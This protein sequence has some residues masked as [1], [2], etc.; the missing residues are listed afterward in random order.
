MPFDGKDFQLWKYQMEIIFRAE[1]GMIEVV[2]GIKTRPGTAGDARTAWD[3]LN[4]KAMLLI[5]SGMEYEQLQTVVSC[6]TAP[7]MWT[8]LKAIHE[9]RSAINKMTL[10]QQFYNYRMSETDSIAQ[11][12]SKIDAIA[13]A[14]RDVG[15]VL[16]D[17]DKIAKALGSLPMKYNGFVTA[18]DSYDEAKQTYDNLTL[19]LLKEEQRLTQVDEAGGAFAALKVGKQGGKQNSTKA[20]QN[21]N[22]SNGKS[23]S[24]RIDKKNIECFHC[25][26]KGHFRSECRKRL[27]NLKPVNEDKNTKNQA[28][29]VELKNI[30][31][32]GKMTGLRTVLRRN[33]CRFIVIGLLHLQKSK[34]V[35]CLFR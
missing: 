29:C 32:S 1:A 31:T 9:Q 30:Y 18:W 21:S 4:I 22:S 28:L 16:N 23:N 19:R 15:E 8:R 14:L 13:L 35:T 7:E 24:N 11:H 2:T 10:K 17:I 25:K 34:T 6:P 33:I 5:S 20:G 27:A 12:I 26:K 3:N